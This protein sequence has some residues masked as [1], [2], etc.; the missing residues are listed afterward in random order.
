MSV[1]RVTEIVASSGKSFED[2]ITHGIDRATKTLHNVKGAW[3]KEQKVVIDD[4][5][6]TEYRVN[7]QVTFV[8]ED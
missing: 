2:A 8:L 5:K 6:I 7:L 3:V 4:D 1:A